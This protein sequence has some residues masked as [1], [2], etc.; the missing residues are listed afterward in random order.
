L[1]QYTDKVDETLEDTGNK[2]YWVTFVYGVATL[3]PWNAV[4][5]TLDFLST[6]MPNYPISFVISFAIN[7]VMILVV[8]LCIAY[9]EVGSHALK[10]NF[11]FVVTA[12]LLI[13]IPFLVKYSAEFLGEGAC[14]WL[15]LVLMVILGTLTAVS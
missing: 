9:Q 12:L 14:F 13:V 4:L 15:T 5:S 3:A 10:V 1:I 7:G 6:S 11:V 8:I 2:I